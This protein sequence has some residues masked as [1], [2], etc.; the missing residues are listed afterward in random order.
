LRC[1]G[2]VAVAVGGGT[3]G[4]APGAESKRARVWRLSADGEEEAATL[5][6]TAFASATAVRGDDGQVAVGGVDGAVRL[7]G[8]EDWAQ[9]AELAEPGD[10]T[11]VQ[12]LAYTP[13][14]RRLV[15]GRWS[16]VF[17]VYDVG[18]G[19]GVASFA[20]AAGNHGW[21]AA[22]APAGDVAAVGGLNSRVLTLRELA[23]PPPLHRWAMGGAAGDA[24]AGAAADGDVVALAMGSRL[25]VHSRSGAWPLLALELGAA[26]GCKMG[27][28]TPVAVRPD[29][30]HVACVTHD[31]DGGHVTC[32]ALPSGAEAFALDRSHLGGS[33]IGLCWSPGGDLLLV[34]GSFG[35]AVFDAAGAK[36]KVLSDGEDGVAV[37]CAA[38]SADGARLATTGGSNKILVRNVGTWE[39]AHALPI[40]GAGFSV[41]FDPAGECVAVWAIDG[42]AQA[43]RDRDR[44]QAPSGS[45]TVHKLDGGGVPQHFPDANATGALAFSADGRFLFGVG[46]GE[47]HKS[48][49]GYDRMVALSRATGAEADWSAALVPMALPPG[50]LSGITLA[51]AVPAEAAAG[52][53]RLRVAVGSEF[54]EIDVGLARRAMD[55]GAWGYAQLVQLA[56][57]AG[58]AAVGNLMARA[59]HCLNIRDPVTGDTL[60][61]HC[62][63]TDNMILAEACLA[64]KT[65]VFVPIANAEGKTALHVALER[66]EQLLV[67][68]L[69]KRLTR[70]LTD[71][72]AALLMD[73]LRTAAL[74]MSEALLPLLNAIEALVLVEYAIVRTL[75]H[76][77]EVI[78][79]PKPALTAL[80]PERKEPEP[81]ESEGADGLGSDTGLDLVPWRGAFPS[82]DKN[83][84][85]TLVALKTL[86]LP[87]LAGDPR[88]TSGGGTF[89]AIVAN[90]NASVF[91]SKLLQYAIQ[92]KFET[93]VLPML[94]REVVMSSGAILL[95]SAATLASARQLEG[96]AEENWVYIDIAQGLMVAAE[97]AQLFTEARQLARQD[98]LSYFSSPWNLM[99]VGAAAA[100]I[101]GAVGTFQRSAEIV[102]HFGA[103]GVALKWFSTVWGSAISYVRLLAVLWAYSCRHFSSNKQPNR[104]PQNQETWNL[105]CQS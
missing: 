41:C 42:L 77:T 105:D 45:V 63:N 10:G 34:W 91:E 21:V 16:G 6:L 83:A 37:Y 22:V 36:L 75:H 40:G 73:A 72:T 69:T 80:D 94:W 47:A 52:A 44:A 8:G 27:I 100:L 1:A 39:V 71:A 82:G 92:Y 66:R 97:L 58:P 99:D 48:Y 79:L 23:P 103:L 26:V 65:A 9:S 4:I 76:R 19:A 50:T 64:S 29:G 60:L 85:H 30:G 43:R 84:A 104:L 86:L 5:E 14:G 96:G 59:P 38:F 87:G 57:I 12:T 62:A 93:N 70:D 102:H 95:A 31:T 56:A 15:A 61:H 68:M 78:G 54:V 67:R 25:E 28:N 74:S 88:D 3:Q 35:S 98:I 20:E 7:F 13:D 89:H 2:G 17:V 46:A 32:R 18:A 33:V 53:A 11:I 51:I 49:P 55:D 101:V 90:C 24:L 81:F